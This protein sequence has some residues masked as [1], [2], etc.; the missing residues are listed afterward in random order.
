MCVSSSE[1]NGCKEHDTGVM[2][3]KEENRVGIPLTVE[4]HL[5]CCHEN[6]CENVFY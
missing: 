6:V 4:V 1:V 3:L 5:N 2:F